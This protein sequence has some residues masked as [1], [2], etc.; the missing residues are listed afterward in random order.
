VTLIISSFVYFLHL[1]FYSVT[2]YTVIYTH[3]YFITALI[4]HHLS[5]LQLAVHCCFQT[6]HYVLEPLTAC[7]E[8]CHL[9]NLYVSEGK[10]GKVRMSVLMQQKVNEVL[11][12]I[13]VYLF[14]W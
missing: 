2:L 5:L 11:Q 13:T 7:C 4:L 8:T 10:L 14:M 6:K 3:V 12:Y 1:V 9:T